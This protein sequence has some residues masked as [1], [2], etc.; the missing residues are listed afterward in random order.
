[1]I[2]VSFIQVGIFLG[3]LTQYEIN[4][5]VSAPPAGEN[6]SILFIYFFNVKNMARTLYPNF[7]FVKVTSRIPSANLLNIS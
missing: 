5:N 7:K 6:I 3:F 4:C 1:M 2:M